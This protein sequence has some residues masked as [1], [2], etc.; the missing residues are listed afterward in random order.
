MISN[1]CLSQATSICCVQR[2]LCP[3]YDGIWV[4]H[5][6]IGKVKTGHQG[7]ALEAEDGVSLPVLPLGWSR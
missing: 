2:A 6:I 7:C 5:R 3:A 4:V 1:K